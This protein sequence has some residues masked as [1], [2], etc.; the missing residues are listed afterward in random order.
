MTTTANS[1]SSASSGPDLDAL[2]AAGG[3]N[4]PV[5]AAPPQKQTDPKVHYTMC[6]ALT[7]VG[8][9]VIVLGALGALGT[10]YLHAA[11]PWLLLIS[12]FFFPGITGLIRGP[13]VPSTHVIPRPK[14]R[15]PIDPT[16]GAGGAAGPAPTARR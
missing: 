13:G 9:A 4:I 1:S 14:N 12:L 11:Y 7:V 10:A 6:I 8:V 3:G 15:K 16:A 2:R 5:T